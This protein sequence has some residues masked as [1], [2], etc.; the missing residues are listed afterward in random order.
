MEGRAINQFDQKIRRTFERLLKT[1][2]PSRERRHALV[3]ILSREEGRLGEPDLG[4]AVL[5]FYRLPYERRTAE[6][7]RRVFG[8]R[9][10]PWLLG[11]FDLSFRT[12]VVSETKI[13]KTATSFRHLIR[14]AIEAPDELTS[15]DL[16]HLVVHRVTRPRIDQA[17]TGIGI[18]TFSRRWR[19]VAFFKFGSRHERFFDEF[20]EAIERAREEKAAFE[21]TPHSF[22]QTETDSEIVADPEVTQT[23]LDWLK[24]LIHAFERGVRP[25]LYPLRRGPQVPS[26]LRLER[27]VRA[28]HQRFP[29]RY[30]PL[31]AVVLRSCKHYLDAYKQGGEN[32]RQTA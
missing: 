26:L 19:D 32:A 31:E 3:K 9:P 14:G 29:L 30:P 12:A 11:Q 22:Y 16:L 18:I 20:D 6:Q 8:V 17:A 23:D 1:A 10:Y 7:F 4:P 27:L 13:F 2:Q 25:P 5:A 28:A 15:V 21:S 24:G